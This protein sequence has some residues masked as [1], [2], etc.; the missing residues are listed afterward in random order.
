MR[1]DAVEIYRAFL[2]RLPAPGGG[3]AHR[4]IFAAGCLGAKSG[5]TAEQVEADVLAHLP[6]GRR[7]VSAREIE[8]GVRAGFAD[9]QGGGAARP[10]RP[11]PAVAP[12]TFERLVKEGA[13]TSA[14]D[15][16]ARSPTPLVEPGPEIGALLLEQL[17]AP[18]EVLFIGDDRSP[19]RVGDSIRPAGEWAELIRKAG[20]VP[21]PKIIPNPLTGRPAMKKSGAGQTLRG[22]G[23]V[24][25]HRFAVLEMDGVG[26]EE[27]LAF[28]AAVRLPV[29]AL[30]HSGGKSI[31][32]WVRVDCAD[33]SE[34]A[35]E[36]AVTEHRGKSS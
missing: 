28:W 31:H 15:I 16:S 5:F 10:R 35:K 11:A 36:P 25:V 13:G 14:A 4:A 19:G 29:A 8:D 32:G 27:Q 26:M 34:W 20:R 7:V 18:D 22:D 2:S 21:W 1:D 33:A 3:G 6:A 17:Y 9:V 24:A 30:I 23:C 12:R